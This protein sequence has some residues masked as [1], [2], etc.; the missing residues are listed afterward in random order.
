MGNASV[1]K[2][3]KMNNNYNRRAHHAGSWYSD[4]EKILDENLHRYLMSAAK[5]EMYKQNNIRHSSLR[6]IIC[7]HAGF[8]YSGPTAAYGYHHLERELSKKDTPIRHILVFHPSHHFYLDGCAVSGATKI[9][10]PLGNLPVDTL[11]REE[12]LNLKPGAFTIM[13]RN[14]DESEHSGEMQYPYIAKVQN[15]ANKK[16]GTTNKIPVLPI[17]CGS[18]SN[19]KESTYGKLLAEIVSRSDVLSIISSDFCHWGDRFNYQPTPRDNNEKI[20]QKENT[21]TDIFEFIRD[22]DNRGMEHISMQQPGAF[23]QYLKETRNTICGRHAIQTW[24][25]AVVHSKSDS[26]NTSNDGEDLSLEFIK[27]AQS[28]EVRS[29]RESSVSYASAV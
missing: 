20:A 6:A 17:M 12:I 16:K 7:P 14:V 25:N 8:D 1:N 28:S 22:L 23:A 18:L 5:E 13:N 2:N 15:D 29:M 4:D 21:A 11:L 27:Y 24:L 19:S 26:K 9:E 3:N 10:T